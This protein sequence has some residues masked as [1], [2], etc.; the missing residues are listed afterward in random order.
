MIRGP[1]RAL[2]MGQAKHADPRLAI[3]VTGGEREPAA[4]TPP[5]RARFRPIAEAPEP[6]AQKVDSGKGAIAAIGIDPRS[7]IAPPGVAPEKPQT[8]GN[9]FVKALGKVNPFPRRAP[10]FRSSRRQASR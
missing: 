3:R 10:H 4:V 1:L 9:R 6:S 5:P 7:P 8:G 2:P